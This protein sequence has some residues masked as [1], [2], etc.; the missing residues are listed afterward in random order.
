MNRLMVAI[1]VL[2]ALLT[3]LI[4]SQIGMLA[5]HPAPAQSHPSTRAL[6][7]AQTFYDDL[8]NVL[9]TPRSHPRSSSTRRM[10]KQ[11]AHYR[12]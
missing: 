7:I 9:A 12:K 11:T 5:L 2:L 3:G 6:T 8:N 4:L 10:D 1:A